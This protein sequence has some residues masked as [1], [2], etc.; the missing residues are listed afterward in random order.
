MSNILLK[1]LPFILI[2]ILAAGY[3]I[4]GNEITPDTIAELLS[5]NY[6]ITIPVILLMFALKSI[7]I[8]FPLMV[9]YLAVGMVFPPVIAI[10]VN[11]AG[12]VVMVTVPYRIGHFSGSALTDKLK[13]KYPKFE[14][15]LKSHHKDYFFISYILRAVSLLPGDAVSM[16][17][18]SLKIPYKK[19]LPASILGMLPGLILT[20][21]IGGSITDPLSPMF[22]ISFSVQILIIAASLIIYS[23]F[24]KNGD[25]D[26][27]I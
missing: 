22:F 6:Y 20:T 8:V 4:S 13:Q 21:L 15:I 18:G 27:K 16:Y 9:L 3:L 7:S 26:D 10:L 11:L 25:K 2:I 5:D 1:I 24:K 19:Y 23:R 14:I 12:I 17:L